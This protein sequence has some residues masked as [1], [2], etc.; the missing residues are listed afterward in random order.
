MNFRYEF[1]VEPA[2]RSTGIMSEGFSAWDEDGDCW[3][4]L[5]SYTPETEFEW[6][7]NETGKEVSRPKNAEIVERLLL[8]FT[9]AWYD[10]LSEEEALT[11]L[12]E[13]AD[14]EDY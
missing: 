11:D 3:C 9:T 10:Q 7:D 4:N 5:K 6:F 14:E 8:E 12:L 2:D 1:S 13:N